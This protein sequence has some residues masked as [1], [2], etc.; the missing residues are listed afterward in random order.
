MSWFILIVGIIIGYIVAEAW[1]GRAV[2]Q[3]RREEPV[4]WSAATRAEL[5]MRED[6]DDLQGI[7]EA[8]MFDDVWF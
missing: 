4:N 2:R 5:W 8:D 6:V 3:A 7:V 1:W